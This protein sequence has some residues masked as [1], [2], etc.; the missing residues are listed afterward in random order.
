[1]S[2]VPPEPKRASATPT[3]P[4][5][6]HA[7][8]KAPPGPAGTDFGPN[9]WLVDE[10][11]QR[12]LADPGSVD[13]AWWNFFAD[14][15]P[16]TGGPEGPG[17]EA[18]G[19][20]GTGSADGPGPERP[21]GPGR[22]DR[23]AP[24]RPGP[25]NGPGAPSPGAGTGPAGPAGQDGSGVLTA[26]AA[27]SASPAAPSAE[28]GP[29]APEADV[30]R[31]RGA[32]ARTATNMMASLTVPTAT[33]VRPVPAKLLIDN[34]IVINNHLGR[35]RG[36]KVSFTHLIGYAIVQALDSAPE[37]N[38]AYTEVDGKPAVVRPEHVNLGLAIDI[39]G[40]DGTRQLLVPSIKAAEA[41]DFRQ[42]WMAY[43]DIVRRAR[44]GK[45]TVEDYAGT[46]ITLTNPGTIGTEHSVPRLMAG[47]GCIVGVGAMEYPAAYQGA[48]DETLARLAISK[49]VTLTSTYDHRIIQ[50]AQSGEFLRVIHGLLL[51]E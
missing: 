8:G 26:P 18:A 2:A 10:L 9:E 37:M 3:E 27:P 46:T 6:D 34:R 4:A 22:Q 44:T 43:E 12:Y 30:L 48:S 50:G 17:A 23:A 7:D 24:A 13:M 32:S 33:S 38:R 28:A 41:M 29:P 39:V 47:Q 16:P 35:G 42:F 19:G 1:M 51:G 36:G 40:R 11:Y 21:G 20:P 15:Q 14:Y 45:L 31:L 5:S 49:T 25:Q